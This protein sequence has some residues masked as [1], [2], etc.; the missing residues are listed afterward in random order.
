MN[1]DFL[2]PL[3]AALRRLGEYATRHEVND[4]TLAEI[5]TD[6]DRARSLVVSAQGSGPGGRCVRHPYSTVAAAGL[7]GCF[8]CDSSPQRPARER[9]DDF[10]PGD[11]LRAVAEHGQE[12]AAERYGARAVALALAAAA[13]HPTHQRTEIS[14][15]VDDTEGELT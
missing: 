9:P 6:L 12:A 3:G 14:A 15:R 7:G 4:A 1:P 8:L 13:R 11:V 2:P 10:V 5:A